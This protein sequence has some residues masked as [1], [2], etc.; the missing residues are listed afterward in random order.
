VNASIIYPQ[1]VASPLLIDFGKVHGRS[2]QSITLSH[3]RYHCC[4][5]EGSEEGKVDFD[6]KNIPSN[7]KVVHCSY[8][9]NHKNRH[10][11]GDFLFLQ[12]QHGISIL[13]PIFS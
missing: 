2:T 9:R 12:N 3:A 7:A 11:W 6:T 8:T 4:L 5:G 1:V 13:L 10:Q